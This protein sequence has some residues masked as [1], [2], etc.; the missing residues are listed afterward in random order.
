M[1]KYVMR[2]IPAVKR[3]DKVSLLFDVR[4]FWEKAPPQ[5]MEIDLSRKLLLS[6]NLCVPFS[7]PGPLREK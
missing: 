7:S 4:I 1:S 6:V 2:Y 3:K 5:N